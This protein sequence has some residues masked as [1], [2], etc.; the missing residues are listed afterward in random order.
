M[1]VNEGLRNK[2]GWIKWAT[3]E[4]LCLT[5][6]G[7]GHRSVNCAAEGSKP[8]KALNLNAM[9][10][11][12]QDN[13]DNE[14]DPDSDYLCSI[15]DRSDVL[16]MYHCEVNKVQGTMLADTGANKN[17]IS[18]RYAKKA[19]L[20]FRRGDAN[21]LRSIRLPNGQD[22]KILGLCEFELKMSEWTGTVVATIL[23]LEADFDVVLGMEWHRQW[24]PLADWDTLDMFVNTPE[25]A[26]RIVHKLGISDV[27]LSLAHR[28]TLLGDWPEELRSCEISLAEA[29]KELKGGAKAYL[30]FAKGVEGDSDEDLSFARGHK[31]DLCCMTANSNGDSA[32]GE[33]SSVDSSSAWSPNGDSS[34]SKVKTKLDCMIQEYKDVFHEEV[35]KG[36]PPNHVVDHVIDT[37]DHNPVNKNAYQ[38]SVLKLQEQTHQIEQL[39]SKGLI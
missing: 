27:R 5:C 35:P 33:N 18:A 36:L 26:L 3:R 13:V 39:L 38:L 14:M 37:G 32:N 25:G 2:L 4:K 22:M 20:R 6:A 9:L 11:R 30:Y 12:M 15:H 19:N 23:D 16:M 17:Y 34:P 8:E 28:L 10:E 24:K 21:S 7:K 31:V 1:I 29:E